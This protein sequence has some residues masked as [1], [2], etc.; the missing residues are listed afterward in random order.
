MAS[1]SMNKA[2]LTAMGTAFFIAGIVNAADVNAGH[3]KHYSHNHNHNSGQI[4]G[5]GIVGLTIGALIANSSYNRYQRADH[6]YNQ[7][8]A[9]SPPQPVFTSDDLYYADPLPLDG[10]NY[11]RDNYRSKNY[12]YQSENLPDP[13]ARPQYDREYQRIPANQPRQLGAPKVIM[14]EEARADVDTIEP[15]TPRWRSYCHNKFRSFNAKTGTFL[16]Y[17]GKHHFCVP[18]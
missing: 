8:R 14:Y 7:Q 2:T 11:R 12:S 10:N 5:A 1:S 6:L 9:Y 3:R 4:I 18:K 17:D 16:G 15:W 13:Q